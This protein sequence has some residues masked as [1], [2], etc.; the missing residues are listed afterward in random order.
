MPTSDLNFS[1]RHATFE[2]GWNLTTDRA[3]LTRRQDASAVVW[4]GTLLPL[5]WLQSKDGTRRAI[6]A[7]AAAETTEL[8]ATG[9]RIGLALA[10]LGTGQ[11]TVAVDADRGGLR[12]ENLTLNWAPDQ[13]APAIISIHYGADILTPEQRLA[14]PTLA[15]PFWPNWRAEGFGLPGAKTAPMQSFFRSWDFGQADIALG[16]FGPAM[17]TPYG[18]AFPRPVYGAG[19]GGRHGWLWCGAG[20]P[21]DGALTLQVRACS[22]SLEWRLREDLWGAPAEH[23]RT[24]T[25]PLT[26]R[27]ADTLWTAIRDTFRAFSVHDRPRASHQKSFWGTWGDFRAGIYD[28]PSTADRAVDEVGA[29]VLCIDDPW[30]TFKG[31]CAPDPA[32]LPRFDADL[33]YIRQRGLGLGIWMPIAWIADPEAV[34]LTADDLLL[35]RDGNP[36][37][38]N[39]ANDPL[40][41]LNA[42]CCLDPSSAAARQFLVER[43]HRVMRDYRPSL[44]K[45][46]F[47]Y[48][49]PGPDGCAPRNPALRGERLSLA[50]AQ[51]IADAAREIDPT[52]TILGYALHPRW[53]AVQDQLSL[54]DLGDAGTAEAAAH[55]QWSVWAALVGAR[56]LA[57]M[58]SSGYDWA[59][60]PDV[61]LDSAILG[62]PGANLPRL[63]ETGDP[64]LAATMARRRAIT[65][66]HRPARA[67][68]PLWLNSDIG[69]IGVDPDARSWGRNER[70]EDGALR[71]TALAL[72]DPLANP[73]ASLPHLAWTGRWA[74]LSLTND[75]V[76]TANEVVLVPFDDGR[77]ELARSTRPKRIVAVGNDEETEF[78]TW[79]W[80][81][82]VLR[83]EYVATAEPWLGLR[84]IS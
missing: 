44:L 29:N 42:P 56:G 3:R 67:W 73:T 43:T 77:L 1:L 32:K 70:G 15:R 47:G 83:V 82:G 50:L 59:A 33:A 27:W 7:T 22:G 45:L 12:F 68:E 21:P 48:G 2:F 36:I 13:S 64:V 72:R 52:V 14:A 35:N 55:R 18:A 66:W 79:Q 28:L 75:D 9:G 78:A 61:L 81:A 65:R 54:D 80:N 53:D 57:I 76:F 51:V 8:H 6:K 24:W 37:R 34:G 39:W 46:D 19:L 63:T 58:G 25:A 62:A 20:D 23:E 40:E 11:L 26:L 71:L 69:Q 74:V 10:D 16:S 60:D 4:E 38:A 84:V 30:E 31:S 49:V 5:F 17:G 41:G